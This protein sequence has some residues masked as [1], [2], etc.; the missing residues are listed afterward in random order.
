[1][2]G[3]N[4]NSKTLRD[5]R[6]QDAREVALEAASAFYRKKGM[7]I[8]MYRVDDTTVITEY[9]VICVGRST[10]QIRA[11]A[12]EAI[13]RLG[14]CGVNSLRTEGESGSE[15]ML[16]DFG[17]VI[18]HIFTPDA[19]TYYNLERLLNPEGEVDLTDHFTQLAEKLK[20][21]DSTQ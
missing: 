8:R 10:T 6:M 14:L 4:E 21:E 11:L 3:N 19:R 15:W 20:S 2:E 5:A 12:D 13:Y 9:Y 17:D 7:D 16:V 18:L 1:M